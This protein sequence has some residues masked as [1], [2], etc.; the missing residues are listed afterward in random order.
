ML[1]GIL[2]YKKWM[3]AID[4]VKSSSAFCPHREAFSMK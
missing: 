4:G 3:F 1:C 2:Y